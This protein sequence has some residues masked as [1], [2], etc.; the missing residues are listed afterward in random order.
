MLVYGSL[1]ITLQILHEGSEELW[2]LALIEIVWKDILNAVKAFG[3][4]PDKFS[5]NLP[6][7]KIGI[8]NFCG[9]EKNI[10]RQ[11]EMT[12][13]SWPLKMF[14]DVSKLLWTIQGISYTASM[15]IF[16]P[17]FLNCAS[18]YTRQC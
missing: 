1:E 5:W 7:M 18:E 17:L 4:T 6:K 3:D 14:W 8:H 2:I 16:G 15:P 12:S 11:M 9:F 10:S 13:S